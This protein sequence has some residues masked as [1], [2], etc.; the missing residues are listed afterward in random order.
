MNSGVLLLELG[1]EEEEDAEEEFLSDLGLEGVLEEAET[2]GLG[3]KEEEDLPPTGF[4]FPP[5]P[6]P[7]P[8]DAP[9]P[10]LGI[11]FSKKSSRGNQNEGG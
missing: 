2:T 6:P 10:F 7:P 11:F 8:P 4:A 9:F 5:P 1:A 3:F